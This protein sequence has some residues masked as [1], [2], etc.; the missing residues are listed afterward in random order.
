MV[1]DNDARR[2]AAWEELTGGPWDVESRGSIP[3]FA[4]AAVFANPHHF[5]EYAPLDLESYQNRRFPEGTRYVIDLSTDERFTVEQVT[6]VTL[7]P[8]AKE[9]FY[10]VVFLARV[11]MTVSIDDEGNASLSDPRVLVTS[12]L[13]ASEGDAT[14]AIA[15]LAPDVPWGIPEW[16]C[17][18]LHAGLQSRQAQDRLVREEG[19]SS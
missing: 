6:T 14:V 3:P 10:D 4:A 5:I 11:M 19:A 8:M 15:A 13:D 12:H 16:D 2:L 17:S 1:A 9:G 7:T 18:N